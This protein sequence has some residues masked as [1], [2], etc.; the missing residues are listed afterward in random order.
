MLSNLFIAEAIS[1]IVLCSQIMGVLLCFNIG[2]RSFEVSYLWHSKR[3]DIF[4]E[5]RLKIY[6]L[7]YKKQNNISAN[8]S[9]VLSQVQCDLLKL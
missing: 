5:K 9:S 7:F 1:F 6:L 8:K 3:L 4:Y 2:I